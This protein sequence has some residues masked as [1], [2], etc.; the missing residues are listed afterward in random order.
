LL[1]QIFLFRFQNNLDATYNLPMDDYSVY[2]EP[3]VKMFENF[4]ESLT[5]EEIAELIDNISEDQKVALS[6]TARALE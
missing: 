5:N 3:I 6:V 1:T 2:V 4:T